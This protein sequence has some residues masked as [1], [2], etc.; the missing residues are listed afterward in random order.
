MILLLYNTGSLYL[1]NYIE[2]LTLHVKQKSMIVKVNNYFYFTT[3]YI[4]MSLLF[5]SSF[6]NLYTCNKCL[7]LFCKY[8]ID[9]I[10]MFTSWNLIHLITSTLFDFIINDSITFIHS[11]T[12][13]R[14]FCGSWNCSFCSLQYYSSSSLNSSSSCLLFLFCIIK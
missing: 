13:C 8:F 3:M 9:V 6:D 11:I 5:V 12:Y 7:F 10:F 14:F 1:I 4:L 2:I